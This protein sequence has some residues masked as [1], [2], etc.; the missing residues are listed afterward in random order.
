MLCM[1]ALILLE[2]IKSVNG[3]ILEVKELS[4]KLNQVG[5][6]LFTVE[7]IYKQSYDCNNYGVATNPY[8]T[9]YHSPFFH[10]M[11]SNYNN[12]LMYMCICNY[13]YN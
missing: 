8:M 1:D 10:T 12:I 9:P 13:V 5:K 6:C 3:L 7:K 2:E 4:E 11:V